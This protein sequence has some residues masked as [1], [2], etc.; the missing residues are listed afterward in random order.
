LLNIAT[1]LRVQTGDNVLIGGFIITGS[2]PK[3][4]VI[5]GIGPSLAQFFSDVLPDPTLELY[6]GDTLLA[7]NND[8]RQSQAEIEATGFQPSNDLES[9]IVRTL[10]PGNYTAVVRGN[11][12]STGIGVV[13]AYDLSP[14]ANSKLANIAT[15]GFV[16]TG[17]N[18]MIGGFITGGDSQVVVRAI[19]P[20]LGNFGISGALQDPTLD[21]VNSNGDVIRS[22]NDWK[23]SQ[24]N[25]ITA[26]G[27]QPGD[28]R[29]SAL[30]ESLP[31]GSYTAV[32]RGA[33]SSTGIGLVEIY[34][35]H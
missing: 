27:L 6:Q 26:T 16:N 7:A 22:N 31:A 3:R 21:L 15:R 12:N 5:R 13:E 32:V 30:I 34:D 18:V 14:S 2:D 10:A 1:R 20:S 17:D 8:W 28:D 25:E 29:E 11:G 4:L 23:E 9:A 33:G 19:G 24:Q 35:Y